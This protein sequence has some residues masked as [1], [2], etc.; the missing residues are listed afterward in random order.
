[1]RRADERHP[2]SPRSARPRSPASRRRLLAR[3]DARVLAIVGAGHQAH[4]H[5]AAMLEARPFE[6]DPDRGP[7]RSRAPSGSPPSGPLADRRRQR[8]GGR[9]RRRRRLHRDEVE[10]AGRS[11]REWL[12]PGAHV[13]AVGACVPTRARA[14]HRDGRALARSSS[15]GASRAMNE[16]GDYLL[17]ARGGRD[18]RA[19]AH[20]GRARRDARRRR[21]RADVGRRDH[22]LR[23]A[24]P[25][26]RGPRRGRVRRPPR[27][28]RPAPG[29]TV[30]F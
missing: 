28:P 7:H 16:A 15:T 3:E 6:R 2:R 13:N 10:R 1:M 21:T 18:L 27:E 23:V 4:P 22:G 12:K 8:R 24:R 5:I 25:G 29:T 17:A 20:Q 26:G 14:R 9:A 19:G 11:R 30:E